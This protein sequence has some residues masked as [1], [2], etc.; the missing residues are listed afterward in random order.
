MSLTWEPLEF[1][2]RFFGFPIGRIDLGGA[3]P[4]SVAEVE[5]DARA[6]G[7]VCLYGSLDPADSATTYLVQTLGYRFV[8]TATRFELGVDVEVPAVP[9]SSVV[10]RGTVDDVPAV[11]ESVL[12]MAPWSR[13]A[14][15]PRFGLDA[16]RRMHMAWVDRAVHCTTG[17]HDLMVADDDGEVVAFLTRTRDPLPIINTVGT[18]APGTGAA[19]ALFAESREWARPRPISAGWAASRNI[20][21]YRFLDRCGF[22]AAEVKY[23]YHRWLDEDPSP[24]GRTAP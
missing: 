23:H 21:I 8:D 17:E 6:H 5:A 15:D 13:Y 3:D 22:V 1:D 11:T 2:S 14:V 9:T 24:A 10:R 4:A 18:V 12:T 19:D 7:V 16:A 20:G